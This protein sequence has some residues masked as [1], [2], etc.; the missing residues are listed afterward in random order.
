V[1]KGFLFSATLVAVGL[2]NYLD[3][4]PVDAAILF[5]GRQ[6]LTR[7]ALEIFRR[8]GIRV[9]TH[10]RPEYQRGH[11]N[12]RPNAHCLSISPF[13]DFWRVWGK[14]PLTR[15]SLETALSWLIDRR[16]GRNLGWHAFNS[17]FAGDFSIR[18]KLNLS[19]NKRMM[20]LFTSSTDEIAGDPG[21]QGPY[22]SQDLW[23]RDVVNWAT[24]RN[25]IELVIRVHPNLSGNFGIGTANAELSFY[26]ELKSKL[27]VNVR[28]VMPDDSLNS[29]VL[30][31]EADIGLTFG[32]T[33]GIEMAM[34]G[35]PVVLGSRAFYEDV[36]N[37]LVVGSKRPLPEILEKTLQP[38]SAREI[39]RHA[40]RWAYRYS[41]VFEAPFPLISAE[42]IVDARLNYDGPGPLTPGMD[43]TLDR[44]CNFLIRG[45]PLHDS[46]TEA[47][48]ART[49]ADED[50]FF[51][52]IENA[53]SPLRDYEYE[54]W[55]RRANRMNLLG[56]S[57]QNA[58][59]RLPF[60]SGN[61]LIRLGKMVY[62]PFLRQVERKVQK[63]SETD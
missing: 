30:T 50:S 22:E 44:A 35:K 6:S 37:I 57:T 63:V 8:L 33:I 26:Q 36:T 51:S 45:Y 53:T 54:R 13:T 21:W 25:D 61:V 2:R 27:P 41:H 23:V 19:K 7:V 10:E 43:N 59:Q 12:L 32:S 20:A 42:S 24:G 46:P 17:P 47:E 28:L 11:L 1:Y 38:Y 29:Y 3:A 16:Y 52:E 15:S 18:E 5:N 49:T 39:R 55:L 48:L 34:L 60:G 56:R 40:F 31:D 9:L 14:V 58:L 62:L 4:N